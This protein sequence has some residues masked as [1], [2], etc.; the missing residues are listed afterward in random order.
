MA[1]T[2]V[3]G[4]SGQVGA[5]L[6][7]RRPQALGP[8][9]A[10]SREPR[11]RQPGVEWRRDS[12][13]S[14]AEC[15]AGVDCILS[16]GPLDVFAA[17]LERSGAAPARV[18][19]L[20][21]TGVRHKQDSAEPADRDEARRLAVAEGVLFDCARRRGIAATLLRPTMIYGAGRDRGL[22]RLAALARRSR[23]LPLPANARG[24][25]QP[26]HVDDVADAVLA[27]LQAPASHGR[28]FDLP[29]AEAVPFD[30][31]VRR[32]LA[33][34]APAARVLR[35]PTPLFTLAAAGLGLAGRGGALRSWLARATRD[36]L[37]DASEARA[38]FAYAPRAFSP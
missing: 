25:R 3:L 17:W 16:L 14:L 26:V 21:S 4:L 34:H 18:V 28:A 6:L 27:C 7:A 33:V 30:A 19:A 23:L 10:L 2:F 36:Q 24:L 32:Y 1:A 8:M 35:L 22:A 9:L 11:A 38:A 29:G 20:G 13:E 15:P 12:L 31:M 5:A 37:A